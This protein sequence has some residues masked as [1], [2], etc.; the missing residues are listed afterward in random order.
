MI[1]IT[2]NSS[3]NVKPRVRLFLGNM[4]QPLSMNTGR[5]KVK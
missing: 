4:N 3:T 1:A 5:Q 2:T